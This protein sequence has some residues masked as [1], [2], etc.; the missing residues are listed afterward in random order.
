MKAAMNLAASHTDSTLLRPLP[1]PSWLSERIWPFETRGLEFDGGTLAV[2]DV[3]QGPALL[4]VH[5][6]LWS[7]VWRDVMA[8]LADDFRCVTFDAPGTGRSDRRP[9]S[10]ISLNHASEAA[11]KVIEA[12]DLQ[13]LTV[14]FH[15]L[16]GPSGIAGASRAR[17]RIRGLV[18]VNTFGWRPSGAPLRAMLTLMGSTPVREIDAVTRILSKVSASAFGVGL[19]MDRESRRAFQAGI[20]SAGL[21]AFHKYLRDARSCEEI[22]R[23]VES[24]LTGPFKTLPFLTI[25]GERNDPFGFQSRWKQMFPGLRQ[26]VIAKGN[27]FPMCDD[28]DVVAEAIRSWHH[29]H[30]GRTGTR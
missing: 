18:A 20:D 8:R 11:T 22:Y 28:P 26:I 25:F 23:E 3:G 13:E 1:R 14:V 5:T 12:L 19:K 2:T 29:E 7:F 10:G 9:L 24:A 15:D 21:R 17:A 4:F 6:G 27:H 30:I 16:G